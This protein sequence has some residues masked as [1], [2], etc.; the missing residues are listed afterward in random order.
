[1]RIKFTLT[2][3]LLNVITFGLIWF[4]DH[5]SLQTEQQATQLAEQI[6]DEVA[7]A[8]QTK[9]SGRAIDLPHLLVR[10]GEN[11]EL[12][13]PVRWPANYFAVN[14][15][16]NQLQ[17]IE[18]EASFTVDAIESSGQSI[19][20]YGFDDPILEIELEHANKT[21]ALALGTPTELG[22]KIYL[23][24]P[25]K[26]LIY[27]VNR[28]SIDSLFT[29]LNA[30]RSRK[31][32]DLPV[33][34]IDALSLQ[35]KTPTGSLKVR[36]AKAENTWQFEAPFATSADPALVASTINTLSSIPVI[37]FVEFNSSD[38][39]A[40]GL[41]D[42]SMHITL[43]GNKREQTL[44]VGNADPSAQGESTY[45][46]RL[47]GR[48][49]V[50]TIQ[51][52]PVDA[53][54]QAQQDLRKRNFF[55]F[56][57]ADADSILI[58][59]GETELRLQK[60]ETGDWQIIETAA[61]GEIQ[62]QRADAQ[63]MSMLLRDLNKLRALNFAIDAPTPAELGQLRFNTP[64]RQLKINFSN[65]DPLE[66]FLA[67]PEENETQLYAR[68]DKAPFVYEIERRLILKL[69]SLN[70]LDYRDRT[71]EQL[72][73]AAR[74]TALK[75]NPLS[76]TEG[77]NATHAFSLND[78]QPDWPACIEKLPI[79]Q[80]AALLDILDAFKNFEVS[81]YLED[82]FKASGTGATPWQSKLSATVLLPDG[83]GGRKITQDY[84]LTDR[85]GGTR[86][87]GGSEKHNC[88]FEINQKL[89]EALYVFMEDMP[90]PPEATEAPVA[91]P[92]APEPIPEP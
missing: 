72:P 38:P 75:I 59:E 25:K 90:L 31:I 7:E 77:P 49:T 34:E 5:R 12:T 35:L 51:A 81:A 76:T 67:H 47:E 37:R 66:L 70:P 42:P 71:L 20:D 26:S 29:D 79:K 80:G 24:G 87:F 86:Q 1:M 68:T 27:V 4:L 39:V 28:S 18:E 91:M 60:L 21:T 14:R 45:F 44:L 73:T 64:R 84:Y 63:V 57:T 48:P 8:T 36:L 85:V 56:N 32:L 3:I 16:L 83:N 55:E 52:Q 30:L 19:S 69:L 74:I 10:N 2:L 65:N 54:R 41:D 6:R 40:Q 33:F 88:S 13:E 92:T 82:N 61:S 58:G 78:A 43:Y 9:L 17:F 62:P 22:N 50:F 46:A 89:M 15:I 23:L 11:W 53:L